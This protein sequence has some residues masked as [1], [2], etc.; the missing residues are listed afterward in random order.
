MIW[1]HDGFGRVQEIFNP[2]NLWNIIAIVLTLSPSIGALWLA[3]RLERRQ[4]IQYEGRPDCESFKRDVETWKVGQSDA[5]RRHRRWYSSFF[6]KH[7]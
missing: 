2:F 7:N 1:Y 4:L 6:S 3:E 5:A